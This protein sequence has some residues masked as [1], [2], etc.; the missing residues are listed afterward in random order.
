MHDLIR[1]HF[2]SAFDMRNCGDSAILDIAPG[3]VAFTTDSY[4]VSPLF[5]PGGNI[6]ELAVYGTVNDLAVSGAGAA[7]LTAGFIIEEAP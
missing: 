4:V 3:R 7:F 5:F 6:G 1:E 2:A